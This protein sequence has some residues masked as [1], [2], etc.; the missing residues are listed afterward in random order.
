MTVASVTV[1]VLLIRQKKRERIQ[2]I[3]QSHFREGIPNIFHKTMKLVIVTRH[4]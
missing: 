3:Y 4:K 2:N 1:N